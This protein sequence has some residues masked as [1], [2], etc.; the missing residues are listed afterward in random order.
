MSE[1]L[2][3]DKK[4][5]RQT[6][7]L[8]RRAFS[9]TEKTPAEQRMLKFLQSWD[10][11]RQAETIHIFISKTDEPDT[12]PI[13]ESAWESGKTVA[14]PCVV[15]DT[16]ELFHSQL[17]TFKDLSSGALGVLEPSP[18]GRIAMNP[19]SFDLVIIPG[20]AFDHLGGRLGYGK[21]YYDRFLEQTG[22]FRLALAF[23]FQVLVRVPT[24]KHDVPMNGILT[25][26]GIIEVNN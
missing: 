19:E 21:G 23:D 1:Q 16:F 15:P 18:E 17:N 8:Q 11:F 5:T 4:K 26:S 2:L 12:S 13:I 20:V 14:V 25:E 7:L 9:A 3:L 22:A 24:E 6:V 10:V